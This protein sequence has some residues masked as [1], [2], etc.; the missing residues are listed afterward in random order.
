MDQSTALSFE[1][2]DA[3]AAAVVALLESGGQ[4][5]SRTI[6][7]GRRVAAENGQRLDRVL[8]QLGLVNERD[9]AGAYATLL[10]LPVADRCQPTRRRRCS[11]TG[12]PPRFLRHAR[13]L[14]VAQEGDTLVLAM[15]DPLDRFTPAAAAA[16]TGCSTRVVVGVPIELEAAFDRLYPDQ[17][18]PRRP[19]MAGARPSEDDTERLKDLA[20]E[21]PVIR[22]VNG[23]IN[24]A[25]ETR[26]PTSISSRS[27]T[28]CACAT[29]M[30]ACCTRRRARRCG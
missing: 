6:E 29:A 1:T 24:R 18:L 8:L 25:V 10:G 28:A 16:A 27:R 15:A 5:D 7:R 2:P 26:R 4:C 23:I 19:T 12:W 11:R 30:T 21:A 20:S 14:P 3:A 17:T 22:L 9:L 13:A